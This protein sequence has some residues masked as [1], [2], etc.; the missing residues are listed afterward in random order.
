MG[1]LHSACIA[2]PQPPPLCPEAPLGV[3]VLMGV[4]LNAGVAA[5]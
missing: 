3:L 5:M 2:P 4:V 1:Q